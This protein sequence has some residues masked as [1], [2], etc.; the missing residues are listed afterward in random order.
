M[1]SKSAFHPR[2]TTLQSS[3]IPCTETTTVKS[4]TLASLQRPK[5]LALSLM[6]QTNV[7]WRIF[8]IILLW[9]DFP[10]NKLYTIHLKWKPK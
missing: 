7:I 8:I 4:L 5:L 3:Q 9:K 2:L 6:Q 1:K 10:G